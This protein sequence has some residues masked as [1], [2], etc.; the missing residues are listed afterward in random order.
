M[1][2]PTPKGCKGMLRMTVS[3]C[4]SQ[5]VVLNACNQ[6]LVLLLPIY[7]HFW[8][9]IAEDSD[10]L[11]HL[12]HEQSMHTAPEYEEIT[13]NENR[14]EMGVNENSVYEEIE[15]ETS[16]FPATQPPIYT[17]EYWNGTVS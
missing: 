13:I 17:V 9:C 11:D 12:A 6:L 16:A 3:D 1:H 8:S 14:V 15:M 7:R 10:C 4:Y 5:N 2:V